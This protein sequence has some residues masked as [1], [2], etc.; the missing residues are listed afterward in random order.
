MSRDLQN[1][2]AYQGSTAIIRN[3]AGVETFLLKTSCA[4]IKSST[5]KTNR[6]DIVSCMEIRTI[7]NNLRSRNKMHKEMQKDEMLEMGVT[8]NDEEIKT[9]NKCFKLR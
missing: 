5:A 3:T 2:V 8:G 9:E 7:R 4:D 6:E 1:F